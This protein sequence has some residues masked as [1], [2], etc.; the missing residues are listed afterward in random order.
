MTRVT[1][2]GLVV[3]GLVLLTELTRVLRHMFIDIEPAS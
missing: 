1:G 2:I 3:T